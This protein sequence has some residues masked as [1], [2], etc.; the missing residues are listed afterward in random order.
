MQGTLT[1]SKNNDKNKDKILKLSTY[2]IKEIKMKKILTTKYHNFQIV[3]TSYS[4]KF[5]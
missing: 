3:S 2:E 4:N 5:K 1:M